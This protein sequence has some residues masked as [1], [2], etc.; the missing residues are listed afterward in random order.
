MEYLRNKGIGKN[1]SEQEF[2]NKFKE[3]MS[4][5]DRSH[6]MRHHGEDDYPMPDRMY[7]D[8]YMRRHVHPDEFD[9][10]FH[11]GSRGQHR[12]FDRFNRM[13]EGMSEDD[14][15]EMMRAMKS[16]STEGEHFNESYAKYL[17]SDM[18]H[19]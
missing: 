18:Y 17:V 19:F 2:I 4:K 13:S 3:L 7:D 1:M 10:R 12:F 5:H 11:S 8:F 16:K 15:Y 14:M 9:E 6:Y